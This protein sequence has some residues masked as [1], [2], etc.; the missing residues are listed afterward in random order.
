MP[1]NSGPTQEPESKFKVAG[2]AIASILKTIYSA[3]RA[4]AT[5]K[6]AGFTLF[7]AF[8]AS[9]FTIRAQ[10]DRYNDYPRESPWLDLFIDTSGPTNVQCAFAFAAFVLI[11]V[12]NLFL[13][14]Q[15]ASMEE[16]M[17]DAVRDPR[18]PEEVRVALMK[19]I[20]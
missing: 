18:C 15:R 6:L 1:S 8:L 5:L 7:L 9:G 3:N 14:W 20:S 2:D 16:K 4:M 19:K 13:R 17:L 10:A 12:V 11:I